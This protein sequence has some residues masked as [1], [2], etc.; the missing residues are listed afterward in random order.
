MATC[1]PQEGMPTWWSHGCFHI[2]TI[3]YGNLS[4]HPQV[5][6]GILVPHKFESKGA[7]QLSLMSN[8][9]FFSLHKYLAPPTIGKNP[10]ILPCLQYECLYSVQYWIM[11]CILL[12]KVPVGLQ[13]ICTQTEKVYSKVRIMEN[14]SSVGQIFQ[15]MWE[16]YLSCK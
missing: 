1:C 16:I 14:V 8:H 3:L 15:D 2:S 13:C 9:N 11:L 7:Y 4:F 5:F 6:N 12:Y 10:H